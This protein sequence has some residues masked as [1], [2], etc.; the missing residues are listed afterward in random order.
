MEMW[1][2]TIRFRA[3]LKK[4]GSK[5]RDQTGMYEEIDGSGKVKE[6]CRRFLPTPVGARCDHM[7]K[8]MYANT[9]DSNNPQVIYNRQRVV[10]FGLSALEMLKVRV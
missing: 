7:Q 5:Y 9:V 8:Y 4:Q 1:G 10:I 3:Y 2:E 6:V